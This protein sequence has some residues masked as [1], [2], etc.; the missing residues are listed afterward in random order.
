MTRS[1][2]STETGQF[3][4]NYLN[5]HSELLV[6]NYVMA[7]TAQN[8]HIQFIN[9]CN[10]CPAWHGTTDMCWKRYAHT[11]TYKY[12]NTFNLII[13]INQIAEQEL[14]THRVEFIEN[15][16]AHSERNYVSHGETRTETQKL[17]RQKRTNVREVERTDN[18][19]F[20]DTSI[21]LCFC[22]CIIITI[23]W[24][25]IDLFCY[26]DAKSP[27]LRAHHGFVVN[28]YPKFP[29]VFSLLFD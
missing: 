29:I 24:N 1:D 26:T 20:F 27:V 12:V 22:F 17:R 15:S 8:P 14:K 13:K 23:A 25:I 2:M 16:Y 11:Q 10:S 3:A 18:G 28:H 21:L 5:D 19:S 6:T 9:C 7:T 4:M